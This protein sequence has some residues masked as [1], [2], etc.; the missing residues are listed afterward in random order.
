MSHGSGSARNDRSRAV[1][2]LR[3]ARALRPTGKVLPEHARANNRSLVLQQLFRSARG[4]LSRADIARQ[5]GLTRVT[6]SDLIAEMVAEDLVREKGQREDARPGKPATLLEINYNALHVLAVDISERVTFRGAI[7]NLRGDIVTRV[8]IERNGNEPDGIG[9]ESTI[10]GVVNLVERLLGQTDRP[11]LGIGVGTPG[12]V[13]VDGTVRNAPNLRWKNLPL[14]SILSRQFDVPV[15]VA[16]DANTAVLAEHSFA[17]S[18]E[19]T[20]LVQLGAGV[21]AGMII[22]GTPVFGA[23]DAAGEIGHVVVGTDGGRPCVCGKNGCL[24]TWLSVPNLKAQLAL[25][26]TGEERDVV[27]MT[28]G[29]RLGIAL[30]PVIAMLNLSEVVL[31]GPTELIEGTLIDAAFETLRQRTMAEIYGNLTLRMTTLDE[32]SVLRGAAVLVLS[33]QLGIS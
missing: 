5:T 26:S 21:G 11:I 32:D 19:N 33:G 16:N 15:T 14:Q 17:G 9:G 20:I 4:G 29:Q 24:E 28:A 7:V 10:N 25:A 30:A 13:G 31:S 6:V 27:L 8:D 12:I 3:Q 18:A 22:D 23:H 1:D 2:N